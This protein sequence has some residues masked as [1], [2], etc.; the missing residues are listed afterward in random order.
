[1]IGVTP[2][3]HL[4]VPAPVDYVSWT[5]RIGSFAARSD[6]R[7]ARRTIWLTGRMSG[8]A[9]SGFTRLGWTLQEAPTAKTP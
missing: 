6:L 1:M 2:A 9:H 7:T 3:G 5:E 8:A 4:V